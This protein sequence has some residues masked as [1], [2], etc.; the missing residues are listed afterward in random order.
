MHLRDD[1]AAAVVDALAVAL[2]V[3]VATPVV[4]PDAAPVAI[5]E[6]DVTSS[7]YQRE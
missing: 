5:L 2:A 4:T 7:H 1:G 3:A 6:Y